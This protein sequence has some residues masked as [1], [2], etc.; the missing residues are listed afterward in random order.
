MAAPG[1]PDAS[2]RG[3]PAIAIAATGAALTTLYAV[4]TSHIPLPDFF[5]SAGVSVDWITMLGPGR[6]A[7]A[8]AYLAVVGASFALYGITV[9]VGWR[10]VARVPRVLLFGFPVLFAVALLFMYPPTAVD[11]FHYHADA[12]TLWV[13]GENP[14]IVPPARTDYPIGISW[15]SDPSPY[16][17]G[18]S[19]LTVPLA[20]LMAFGDHQLATL[21]AFKA[22][23]A[24]SYLGCGWLIYRIVRRT[25]P[26]CELFAFVLFAWNPFVVLR[27]VGN[28]HN[29]LAMMFFAL[30]ALDRAERRDWSLALP[31][32]ALSVL[33]KYTTA[34]LVPPLLLYAWWHSEGSPSTRIRALAPGVGLAVLTTVI[35]Y[36]P[37]WAGA[38]TF[39]ALRAEGAKMITST[40][41][42]VRQLLIERGA[43]EGT[44]T[45]LA[46]DGTR[47]L[48][49]LIAIP[50]AWHARRGY[51]ALLVAGFTLLFLY[52]VIASAWFRPWYMLWPATLLV[53]RPARWT[54]ALFLAITF[55]NALPD[56][57]EHYRYDWGLSG[58]YAPRLAPLA[59]QFALPLL[60][61]LA[62]LWRFRGIDL[63]TS[64][65]TASAVRQPRA[66]VAG[67]AR[68]QEPGG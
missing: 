47:T 9:V 38:A 35:C 3:T 13:F 14:L 44:A 15:A 53:L 51:D 25:R 16:G 20:P 66:G 4:A 12:R 8:V 31:L 50:I 39:D 5:P 48:F 37:F 26:G 55:G 17:P 64:P 2:W 62:A 27:A 28:G 42:L 21:I 57:I 45:A 63:E 52:L 58:Q 22:L 67:E 36:A 65:P 34:L 30:L 29:D 41:E 59:T 49:V 46:R 18:W 68:S 56:L 60:I 7:P 6:R 33:L 10:H 32:I 23:G 54:V 24:A 19:L 40:A 43:G 11:L 1:R 61:W